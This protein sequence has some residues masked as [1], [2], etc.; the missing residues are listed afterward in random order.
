M[1]ELLF[2]LGDAQTLVSRAFSATYTAN[3]QSLYVYMLLN[4]ELWFCSKKQQKSAFYDRFQLER[5]KDNLATYKVVYNFVQE[6]KGCI[7][8]C[9]TNAG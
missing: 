2:D 6:T 7:I 3:I 5:P 9:K 8:Y 4:C 1:W